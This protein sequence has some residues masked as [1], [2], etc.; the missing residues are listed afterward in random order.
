MIRR[1]FKFMALF[2]SIFAAFLIA[3]VGATADV[4]NGRLQKA[5]TEIAEMITNGGV[6]L[7][8]SETMEP[9]MTQHPLIR[10]KLLLNIYPYAEKGDAGFLGLAIDG[11]PRL[12]SL[13]REMG[14]SRE[15]IYGVAGRLL[16]LR[17]FESRLSELDKSMIIANARNDWKK[18]KE[19]G[20]NFN[21]VDAPCFV[22]WDL[23]GNVS[24]VISQQEYLQC[25]KAGEF[26]IDWF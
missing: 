4:T 11:L 12:S 14:A 9:W 23:G 22:L 15:I 2:I 26:R 21:F 19:A 16:L 18:L 24:D 7:R 20:F 3:T 10:S 1:A 6:D 5:A 25:V 13:G 17:L 8:L